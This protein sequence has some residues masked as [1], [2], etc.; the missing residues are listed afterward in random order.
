MTFTKAILELAS[1]V[2][3]FVVFLLVRGIDCFKIDI[4][5]RVDSRT[6]VASEWLDC[7]LLDWRAEDV[8]RRQVDIV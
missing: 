7:S 1:S 2:Q 3:P 4:S 6:V 5:F 8:Q